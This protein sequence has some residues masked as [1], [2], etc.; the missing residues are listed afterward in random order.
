MIAG[1]IGRWRA[2]NNIVVVIFLISVPVVAED[3]IE[4]V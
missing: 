1:Y 3:G 2:A 4:D